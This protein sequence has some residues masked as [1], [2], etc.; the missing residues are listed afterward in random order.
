MFVC[1]ILY[2]VIM[3]TISCGAELF[4][5][6]SCDFA[7]VTIFS[8]VDHILNQESMCGFKLYTG[9]WNTVVVSSHLYQYRFSVLHSAYELDIGDKALMYFNMS[10]ALNSSKQILFAMESS[11]FIF[12]E[13]L[14][15]VCSLLI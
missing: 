8:F 9:Y 14:V 6:I 1:L 7:H 2:S 11:F 3:L 12:C 10:H 15:C 5:I 13:G 4:V